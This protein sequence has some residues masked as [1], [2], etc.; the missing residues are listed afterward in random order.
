MNNKIKSAEMWDERFSSQEYKYGK[1]AN[2][3][4]RSNCHLI[5]KGEVLSIGEGEGRNSVFLAQ[6][7]FKVTALDYS[8]E[9]LKKTEKLAKENS[10]DVELI[11]AD[12]TEYDFG[13]KKW[14][15]IV[16]I[17]CHIEPLNRKKVN[18]NCVRA[19]DT[20]GIF[21]LE[22]YSPNQLKYN[23]GGPK[24]LDL[25]MDLKE[26]KNELSG[27]NFIESQEVVREIFEGSLHKGL[28]SVIQIIG[29]KRISK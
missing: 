21:L 20:N 15:G 17:F 29:K 28:G 12:V 8:I 26:V 25:L 13:S 11:H 24:S 23:T 16:S 10:V 3:F 19:L 2:D 7:G 18:N 4:I 22:A 14:Q 5:P 27:L 6:Q 1:D 9:G